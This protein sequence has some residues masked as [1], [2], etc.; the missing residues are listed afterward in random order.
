[1]WD[2]TKN[3]DNI[4]SVFRVIIILQPLH[5][6]LP[7]L[8]PLTPSAPPPPD[9]ERCTPPQQHVLNLCTCP[10]LSLIHYHTSRS[11]C[12]VYRSVM[13]TVSHICQ[14]IL[15]SFILVKI[16]WERIRS[17]FMESGTVTHVNNLIGFGKM[18]CQLSPLYWTSPN[19]SNSA[20][21][22][23]KRHQ[24]SINTSFILG[25]SSHSIS[26]GFF[27]HLGGFFYNNS[28]GI[29]SS[30]PLYIWNSN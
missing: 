29:F 1:M 14:R 15:L 11:P 3:S 22:V 6:Q 27:K 5:T 10:S 20:G 7:P 18:L 8:T 26:E 19:C 12:C 21:S 13:H 2:L 30:L 24:C 16:C 4:H 23:S 17:G 9:Q 25:L 28:S